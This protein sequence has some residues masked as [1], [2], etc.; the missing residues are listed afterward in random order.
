[1]RILLINPSNTTLNEHCTPPL[2]LLYLAGT[3]ETN[4]IDCQIVDGNIT[5]EKSVE[6]AIKTGFDIVG[7][8][9]MTNTRWK[10]FDT[11]T[12][13]RRLSK[14][15]IVL[16]GI[17]PS[18]MPEQCKKFADIVIAGD[19]ERQFLDVCINE[20]PKKQTLSIDD[21]P[22]PAW[23]KLDLWKYKG[24]GL[25]RHDPRP[26]NGVWIAREP[27]I[28]IQASRGCTSH[29]TFCSSWWI[30][31]KY[32]VRNPIKVVDELEKLYSN[33]FR[34]FY[35]VDDAWYLDREKARLFCTEILKR[36]MKIA[37]FILTRIEG[38]DKE[39]AELLRE[40]GCY[41]IAIGVETGSE[42]IMESLHKSASVEET[43]KVAKI[44]REVG[45][46]FVAFIIVGNVGETSQSIEQTRNLMKRIKPHSIA[47][48]EG[49]MILPKTALYQQALREGEISEDFFESR[50]PCK[51]YKYNPEQIKKWRDR[52]CTY[53]LIPAIR[54]YA[55]KIV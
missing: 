35:F 22:S 10:S 33:G 13:V 16:G 39:M 38:I 52:I 53:N 9:C 49:L 37:Y 51:I 27:R 43:E 25:T 55:G 1:M 2:N 17:H 26:F 12:K 3:L 21:I 42:E 48:A 47:S 45:L 23:H 11:A 8:T 34:N 29:C 24:R 32:R 14:S 50:E 36:K 5:G 40:S 7:I 41:S 28:L 6:D 20:T 54:H 46:N 15:K 30:F 44:C 31:G 19:G 4:N 18:V